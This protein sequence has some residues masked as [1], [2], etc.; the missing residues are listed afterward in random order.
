[1]DVKKAFSKREGERKREK[2][3]FPGPFQQSAAFPKDSA[4]TLRALL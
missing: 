3:S 4:L 1:V 2:A